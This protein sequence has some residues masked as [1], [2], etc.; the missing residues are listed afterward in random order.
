[1]NDNTAEPMIPGVYV[2]SHGVKR[3]V[4]LTLETVLHLQKMDRVVYLDSGA[5]VRTYLDSLGVSSENLLE[6][7]TPGH[8][9][10]NIYHRVVDH[11]VKG[12]RQGERVAYLSQGN[13][14]FLDRIATLLMERCRELD[15]PFR[16]LAGVSSIDTILVDLVLSGGALGFQ[17][18]E[19]TRFGS[20]RPVIDTQVPLLLFQI[21]L[22]NSPT[23]QS[24]R[25]PTT[26]QLKPL[27][28]Y[29]SELYPPETRWYCVSSSP[30]MG[31]PSTITEGLVGDGLPAHSIRG[32]TLVIPGRASV[33]LSPSR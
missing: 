9:R 4:H 8:N 30:Q 26:E 32:G 5:E 13:A 12:A 17:C 25:E 28:D 3:V 7:Y 22:F 33:V 29:L 10:M 27:A 15:L 21:S 16:M 14:P 19:A 6:W 20:D 11:I 18:H 24:G 23:V 1:M 2:L 31:V